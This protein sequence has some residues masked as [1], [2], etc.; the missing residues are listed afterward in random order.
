[1]AGQHQNFILRQKVVDLIHHLNPI[2]GRFPKHEKFALITQIKNS[3]YEI[4]KLSISVQNLKDKKIY[5]E[6]LDLEI[7]FLKELVVFSNEKKQSY[8]SA[9]NRKSSMEKICEIGKILGGL[10]KRYK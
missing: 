6:R 9:Q 2:L 10:A 7:E 8:L 5:I 3:L 1:M 4:L